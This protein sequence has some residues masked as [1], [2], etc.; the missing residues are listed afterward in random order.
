VGGEK[1]KKKKREGEYPTGTERERRIEWE[2]KI[3]WEL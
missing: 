3:F 1:K 2:K